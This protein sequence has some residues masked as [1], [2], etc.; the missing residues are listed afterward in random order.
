MTRAKHKSRGLPEPTRPRP[1]FCESCGGPPN[2]NGVL[3]LDHCHETGKF[4]G[5]LCATCNMGLGKLGDNI[6][7][8]LNIVG[9]L[10]RSGF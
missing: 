5:W 8:V 7:G 3:H 2:G 6:A 1:E 9:Y 10:D 4:R